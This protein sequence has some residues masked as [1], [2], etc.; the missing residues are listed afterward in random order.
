[1]GL[2]QAIAVEKHTLVRGQRYLIVVVACTGHHPKRH[3]CCPQFRDAAAVSSIRP[4]MPGIGIV[5]PTIIRIKNSIEAGDKHARWSF[6][7]E[8]VVDPRKYFTRRERPLGRGTNHSA[9]GRHHQGGGYPFTGDITDDQ[10]QPAILKREEIVEVTTD[11]ACRLVVWHE[12]PSWE[13]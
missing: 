3:P 7:I 8:Q 1:M 10:T 4:I 13:R 12:L 5:Q 9:G 2:H 11:L 6:R